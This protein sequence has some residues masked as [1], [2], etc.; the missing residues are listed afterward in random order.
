MYWLPIINWDGNRLGG[1][2]IVRMV[3]LAGADSVVAG[4]HQ[5]GGE[6]HIWY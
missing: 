5:A 2:V 1:I 4:A 6:L 3:V